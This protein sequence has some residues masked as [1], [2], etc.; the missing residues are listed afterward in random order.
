VKRK[1]RLIS[2]ILFT[3]FCL[4]NV[5]FSAPDF[6]IVS[7]FDDT[8][9]ITGAHE[10]WEALGS[11]L[12]GAPPI[13]GMVELSKDWVSASGQPWNVVSGSPT[14]LR[15]F[16]AEFFT[17]FN[18]PLAHVFLK[19]WGRSESMLEYKTKVVEKLVSESNVPVVL[20]G[21]DTQQ[22]PETFAGIKKRFPE[23]VASAYIHRVRPDRP[24]LPK[25]V[26]GYISPAELTAS[27]IKEGRLNEPSLIRVLLEIAKKPLIQLFPKFYYC[28]KHYV[29]KRELV[30]DL[31]PLAYEALYR[32]ER[33]VETFCN[34]RD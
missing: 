21:D 7:D 1:H 34:L 15:S 30:R 12:W 24:R 32:H 31:D 2:L 23:K 16:I 13:S 4:A 8:V 10:P 9:K 29:I 3:A 27:E 6:L 18:L 22:D 19:S 26:Q 33:A 28:P 11:T 14:Q 25:E 5:A 17:Q 20:V